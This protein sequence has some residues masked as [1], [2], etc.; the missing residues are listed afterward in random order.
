MFLNL[1]REPVYTA[2]HDSY[3]F[4]SGKPMPP[5]LLCHMSMVF[6]QH[7]FL[8]N[9]TKVLGVFKGIKKKVG[10]IVIGKALNRYRSFGSM[11]ILK[12]ASLPDQE[13]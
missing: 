12:A 3:S 6:G 1:G 9:H 10:G 2:R 11:I 4:V 8:Y 7:G 13:R 5:A